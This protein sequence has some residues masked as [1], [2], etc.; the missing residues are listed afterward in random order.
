MELQMI[1][2]IMQTPDK[3]QLLSIRPF[4]L[5]FGHLVKSIQCLKLL[6]I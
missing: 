3:A 6:L 1:L 5:M 4:Y 2:I